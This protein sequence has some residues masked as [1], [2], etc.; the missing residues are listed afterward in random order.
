MASSSEPRKVTFITDVNTVYTGCWHIDTRV[1][2]KQRRTTRTLQ[3]GEP[4]P[5]ETHEVVSEAKT[6][7][8]CARCIEKLV[9]SRKELN[10]ARN[11]VWGHRLGDTTPVGKAFR[12][13]FTVE[14]QFL[15]QFM[16]ASKKRVVDYQDSYH[17]E[18]LEV[19]TRQMHHLVLF[20]NELQRELVAHKNP[21]PQIVEA[22]ILELGKSYLAGDIW[23]GKSDS[24]L[25]DGFEDAV[26]AIMEMVL[27]MRP[28]DNLAADVRE[29]M[30]NEFRK[31]GIY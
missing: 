31:A 19:H 21:N 3:P 1:T 26:P 27:A 28:N 9:E 15:M 25:R 16:Q 6:Q 2:P 22:I 29:T 7:G 10:V 5:T 23:R 18:P 14:Q 17:R 13:F 24:N 20:G 11:E 12:L 8:T 4:E 30:G